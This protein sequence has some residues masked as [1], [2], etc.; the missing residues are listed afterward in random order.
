[1]E[2]NTISPNEENVQ[3]EESSNVES[4]ATETT[5]EQT[6]KDTSSKKGQETVTKEDEFQ[7]PELPEDL[8]IEAKEYVN[9]SLQKVKREM[10]SAFTKKTQ[11]LANL[12][13]ETQG[14]VDAFDS[15]K[16]YLPLLENLKKEQESA[17]APDLESMSDEERLQHFIKDVVSTEVAPYKERIEQDKK[18]EV[19]TVSQQQEAEAREYAEQV[20][21]SFDDYMDQMIEA[22]SI[23][24]NKYSWKQLLRLVAADDI[25]ERL[26]EKGKMSLLEK[27]KE[28]KKATPAPSRSGTPT[29]K[30][31]SVLEA[32]KQA[33]EGL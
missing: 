17:P 28:K 15:I 3:P 18:L 27:L 24:P 13:K 20:G 21:V 5:G 11:E 2:D 1:M 25:D 14:K 4:V 33:K 9:L 30:P 10:Q 22:D 12:R 16:D 31:L 29:S 19:E 26:Q 23:S 7:I 8:P 32:Y 6:T